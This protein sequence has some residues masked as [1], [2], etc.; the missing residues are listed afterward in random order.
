[1]V[2]SD[3]AIR[4]VK[5]NCYYHERVSIVS[6]IFKVVLLNDSKFSNLTTLVFH[7]LLLYIRYA[8]FK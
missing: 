8:M 6:H 7:C 2:C 5:S 4:K 1:M 3:I